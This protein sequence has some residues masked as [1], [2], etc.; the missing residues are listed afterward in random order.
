MAWL[1]HSQ[2]GSEFGCSR[3]AILVEPHQTGW[4][5]WQS[6]ERQ[7]P[8]ADIEGSE[9]TRLSCSGLD[10]LAWL[11]HCCGDWK[12]GGGKGGP[13]Q[14]A[15]APSPSTVTGGKVCACVCVQLR[16]VPFVYKCVFMNVHVCSVYL[17]LHHGRVLLTIVHRVCIH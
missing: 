10:R 4:H 9:Y 16:C 15:L 11:A 8:E 5:S 14:G 3:R 12:S 1:A 6:R 17:F 13:G 2:T 7:S